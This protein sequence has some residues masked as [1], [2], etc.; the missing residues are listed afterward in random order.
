MLKAKDI[1]PKSWKAAEE[2]VLCCIRDKPT[3]QLLLIHKKRGLGAGLINMPGGRIEPGETAVEAAVRETREE[4]DLVV[5]KLAHRGDLYF[6]FTDGHSIRCFVFET[7]HWSGEPMETREAA[8]FWCSEKDIP[9][10]RMWVDDSWWLPHLLAECRFQGRFVFDGYKM[11]SMSM[12]V[13]TDDK[14][15]I[16]RNV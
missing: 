9:Y 12:D 16:P 10:D 11:L 1:V 2:A 15:G 4:V 7:Q 14:N 6:Q 13:E 3:Q 5:E 8:P